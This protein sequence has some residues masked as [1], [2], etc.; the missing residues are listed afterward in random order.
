MTDLA[1]DA[2]ISKQSIAYLVDDLCRLGYVE[3]HEHPTDGRARQVRFTERGRVLVA[4]LAQQSSKAEKDCAGIIGE[5]S[6]AL[7]REALTALISRKRLGS[8]DERE[9]R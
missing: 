8:E 2:G 1:K 7:V 6:M 3:M 9:S 5:R 4:L